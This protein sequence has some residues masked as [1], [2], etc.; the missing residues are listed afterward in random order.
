MVTIMVTILKYT[1]NDIAFFLRLSKYIKQKVLTYHAYMFP[2]SYYDDTADV[3]AYTRRYQSIYKEHIHIKA[4][5]KRT[6]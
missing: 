1:E 6:I 3:L 5:T 2:P 4:Y